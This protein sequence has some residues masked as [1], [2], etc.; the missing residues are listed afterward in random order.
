MLEHILMVCS[1]GRNFDEVTDRMSYMHDAG[2]GYVSRQS[3]IV[4]D[5]LKEVMIL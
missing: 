4:S 5:L 2:D 1:M 3:R